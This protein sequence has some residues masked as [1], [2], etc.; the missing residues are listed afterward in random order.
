MV[1]YSIFEFLYCHYFGD[2][3]KFCLNILVNGHPS[4]YGLG[5][6]WP[7]VVTGNSFMISFTFFINLF[8]WKFIK[9]LGKIAF[10]LADYIF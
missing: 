5:I 4:F 9:I 3:L 10:G 7:V 1:T 6:I 2:K 8:F